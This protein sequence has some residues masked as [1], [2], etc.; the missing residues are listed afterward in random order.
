MPHSERHEELAALAAL[1]IPNEEEARELDL[2][3][4][5]GCDVCER[6]LADFRSAAS[7]LA[8]EAP[9]V[10]PGAEV[11]RRILASLGHPRPE[12]QQTTARG[13][14]GAAGWLFAAAASLLFV[15][16]AI[17][18][19]RVRRAREE[20]GGR[21]AAANER[22]RAAQRELARRDLRARVLESEDVRILFLSGQGPQPEARAR[23]FWSEQAKRG[24][25]LAGRLES[26][27]GDRQY[28]LWVFDEGK[29]VDAGV[30]DVDASGR[31]FYESKDLSAISRAENFAVTI[32]P[33]GG[34]PQP[35]G[36]I[37]LVGTP[38]A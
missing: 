8:V 22:L 15:V 12:P 11:R 18:D 19:L 1:S 24:V 2:H 28:Q 4:A 16:V 10:A 20:I 26:L 14:A 3:L 29:P 9:P 33:R 5:E 17:D 7:A 32:E 36:P 30:F 23:V 38:S 6:L 21:V 37:V 31:A 25:L 34:V 13:G 35:T 27:A